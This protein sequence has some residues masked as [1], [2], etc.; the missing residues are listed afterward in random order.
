MK[1]IITLAG[2]GL[3]GLGTLA[4]CSDSVDREGTRDNI[5][6][7]FEEGG[8]QVDEDCVDKVL[9]KYDDDELEEFDDQLNEDEPSE[10]AVAFGTEILECATAEE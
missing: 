10:A 8:L 1:R 9:D 4:A 3:F 6:E 7:S 2:L 5:V